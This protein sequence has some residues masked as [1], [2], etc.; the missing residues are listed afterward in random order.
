MLRVCDRKGWTLGQWNALSEDEQ[1]E[2]LAY[3]RHIQWGIQSVFS[4]LDKRAKND[5]ANDLISYVVAM[6]A[7]VVNG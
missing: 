3:Q 2:W 1:L 7:T 4:M 6:L 5:K